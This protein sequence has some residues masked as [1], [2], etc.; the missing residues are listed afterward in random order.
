MPPRHSL[1]EGGQAFPQAPQLV[2]SVDTFFSQPF[3][4]SPSQLFQPAEH[5]GTHA[6]A[7]QD[8]VPW[9]LVHPRPHPPQCA[10]SVAVSTQEPPQSTAEPPHADV[11][12]PF[13]QT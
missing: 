12:V 2:G 7:V 13:E 5:T 4:G 10:G 9:A 3:D 1:A 6:P 11:H 8:V